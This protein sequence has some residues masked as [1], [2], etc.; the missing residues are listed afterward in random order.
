MHDSKTDKQRLD[1][2]VNSSIFVLGM[3]VAK[4]GQ[5]DDSVVVLAKQL[6]KAGA[7][8]DYIDHI[9]VVAEI[10]ESKK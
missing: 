5:G 6:K 1:D 8:C 10:G 4:L 9:L 7:Q 2:L 3:L